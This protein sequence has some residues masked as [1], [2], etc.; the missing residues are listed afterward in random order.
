MDNAEILSRIKDNGVVGAGGAGFPAYF[1]LSARADTVIANAAE[2]EPL[3]YSDKVLLKNHPDEF[4]KGLEIAVMLTGARK[5]IIGI[6]GKY[7]DIISILEKYLSPGIEIFPLPDSYPVG[8]EQVLVWE[9]LKRIVPEGGLPINVGVVVQNAATLFNIYNAVEKD[10]PVIKKYVTVTGEVEKPFVAEVAIGTEI[11]KLIE[12]AG[13]VNRELGGRYEIL[14]GGPMTGK[15]VSASHSISKTTGGVI[16]LPENHYIIHQLKARESVI[17]KKAQSFC[18][19]CRSC[20]EVCP[21]YLIGHEMKPDQIMKSVSIFKEMDTRAFLCCE[22]GL[23]EVY[24][25]PLDLSPRLV[26]RQL[27]ARLLSEGIMS[28]HNVQPVAVHSTREF[29]QIPSGRLIMKAHLAK[30]RYEPEYLMNLIIPDSVTVF[31][32]QHIGVSA[33]PMVNIGDGVK[34]GQMIGKIGK[35]D[36]GADVH[37]PITG[38][39]I[40]ADKVKIKIK[41]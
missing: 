4:I 3:L 12:F 29:R 31:L 6:K 15:L 37:S 26:A 22:C 16:I 41:S 19:M 30:Y 20:T 11:S 40:E 27:K 32:K 38:K 25:C 39:V 13:G 17:I 34:A 9:V 5:G 8:D 21:R 24:A 2:C 33:K 28:T 36:L 23:C 10:E 35:D 18:C 14:E 1:K 7:K